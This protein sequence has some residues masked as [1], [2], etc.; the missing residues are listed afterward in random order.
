MNILIWNSLSI[1]QGDVFFFNNTFSKT[2]IRQCNALA[3]EGHSVDIIV[4]ECT[5]QFSSKI[6]SSVKQIY[7]SNNE[8]FNLMGTYASYDRELY[9]AKNEDLIKSI[10]LKIA[11]KLRKSY[12]AI[13]LWETPVPFL[14]YLFP[15]AIILNQMPGPFCK[16]PYP[17]MITIDLEGLYKQGTLYLN[18]SSVLNYQSTCSL[19]NDFKNTS[20]DIF[21][22]LNPFKKQLNYLEDQ[23]K[24]LSLLP[25]Q[26]TE[27]YNFKCDT[28]YNSQAEFLYDVLEKTKPD[29]GLIVTQYISKSVSDKCITPE[30]CQLLRRNYK[31][32]F[33]DE[34]FDS[35]VAP[36]QYIV[37]QVDEL[38]SCSSSLAFQAMMFNKKIRIFGKTF[39]E[40][41]ASKHFVSEYEKK[42][43][44]E[45]C[46]KFILE[47]YS[48]LASNIL[49][50]KFL[51]NYLEEAIHK[52]KCNSIDK[53]PSLLELSNDYKENILL[54]FQQLDCKKELVKKN[55]IPNFKNSD[56]E[57]FQSLIK[58][59]SIKII[60]FD[61]F[62]TLITRN[63]LRPL[64]VYKILEQACYKFTHGKIANFCQLRCIA[65][66]ESRK[67]TNSNETS[68][69]LIYKFIRDNFRIDNEILIKLKK[70]EINV[71]HRIS[72]VQR[73]GKKLFAIAQSSQKQI[74]YTSDM[75]LAKDT[76]LSLLKT[77][78]YPIN[79]PLFLS[80][81]EN[82][83]KK[84]G[85]LF[86]IIF[87]KLKISPNELLHV[88]DNNNNDYKIPNSKGVKT[89]RIQSPTQR[90]NKNSSWKKLF[91][92]YEG[93]ASSISLSLIANKYW[94]DPNS[95]DNLS[96]FND[97]NG[98]TFGYSC[99][100][101]MIFGYTYWILQTCIEKKIQRIFFLAREGKFCKIAYDIISKNVKDAPQSEY[102]YSSRRALNVSTLENDEDIVNIASQ[103]FTNNS[104]L[105]Q[106]IIS[107]FGISH[108]QIPGKYNTNLENNNLGKLKLIRASLDLKELI[109][110]EA[111][112]E[113]E[114]YKYYIQNFNI[115]ENEKIAIV[116]IGWKCR[117][118]YNLEILLKRSIVGFYYSTVSNYEYGKLQGSNIIIYDHRYSSKL[119]KHFID[120]NRHTIESILCC[121]DSSFIKF[122]KNGDTIKP[123]FDDKNDSK[124]RKIILSNFKK[125]LTNFIKDINK[126][127]Y[128]D[129]IYEMPTDFIDTLVEQSCNSSD[130][131]DQKLYSKLY[132]S[133]QIGGIK[134][135]I[136]FDPIST[137]NPTT[138][139]ATKI[140]KKVNKKCINQL[141]LKFESKL[142]K[143]FIS[144]KKY[145]K[146]LRS[147]NL[148]FKD[149]RNFFVK[150][151]Y[152]IFS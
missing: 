147:R 119:S 100:G 4:T 146:Y 15:S 11:S 144:P 86:D 32:F 103:P 28:K 124:E 110:M 99:L 96:M 150:K 111:A 67:L 63:V 16:A 109:Y 65:E 43:K 22:A 126:V 122:E 66:V 82:A 52:K 42:N 74:I 140:E 26:V 36:S 47:K 25:L 92:N 13:L 88:G 64:D 113:K 30:F 21:S 35:V 1:S 118:Q 24:R 90:I 152:K 17:H 94:S 104:N 48:C 27:H 68:L 60:S 123:L 55:I 59:A 69:N 75:Y 78:G 114:L 151:Y 44:Y 136:C 132:F 121:E 91:D 53:Y 6:D 120:K 33:Y 81:E 137:T 72:T 85:K 54:S 73:Y 46:C 58:D 77:N 89:F 148:F 45:S 93:L 38:V 50:G 31:N 71:E 108:A 37:P 95:N 141:F 131:T 134:E 139:N 3:K 101:P 105:K 29:N 10:S 9:L 130:I 145:N 12:D 135:K 2:L 87:N 83:S 128:K 70:L 149:S 23:F 5:S 51:S 102:L 19:F 125:G 112:K 127:I 40:P 57:K 98:E 133:D 56:L 34:V 115:G 49:E 106:L 41:Y 62:D 117:M 14:K 39:V 129:Y 143:L 84:D 107:R 20:T 7:F 18:S 138:L 142:L 80:V 97:R 116:D 79:F 61:I 76:I 8:I